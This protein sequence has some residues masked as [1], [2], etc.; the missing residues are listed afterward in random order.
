M[1]TFRVLACLGA[2]GLIL[3]TPAGQ[4]QSFLGSGPTERFSVPPVGDAMRRPDAPPPA[5]RPAA[6]P[7]EAQRE[8]VGRIAPARRLAATTDGF[9]MEGEEATLRFPV[10][11]TEAQTRGRPRLRISYLSAISVAPEASELTVSVNGA[12]VGRTNI[13]AP[14]AVKVVEFEIPEGSLKLGYNAVSL[15]ASQRHRVDCSLNATYELWTQIDPSRSGLVVAPVAAASLELK[16]LPALEPDHSGALPVR[17]V[18]NDKP[19]LPRLERM[20]HAVEA[21]GLIGRIAR[22]VVEFGPPM[23]GRSGL[24]LIVGTAA[25]LREMP[26][27]ES[28]G[29][30]GGPRLVVLPPRP[31]R[32]PTL[33]VTGTSYAEIE[34]A[35]AA[36]A[37]GGE[38]YG[39]PAGLKA[40]SLARGTI[41]DGDETVSLQSLGVSTREFS[42]RLLR[43]AFDVYLPA[44]FLPADYGKVMLN[45]AGAYASGLTSDARILVDLNGSNAASV[46]LAQTR[47]EVF[48]NNTIP[49]PLAKWRPGLNRVAIMAQVPAPADETCGLN[50]TDSKRERFL[51]L[52]RAS[53]SIPTLAHAARI[54]DLAATTSGALAFVKSERRPRLVLPTLDKDT[55]AAAATLAARLAGAA[56]RMIDF[57]LAGDMQSGS[58]G[59]TLVVAP[60]RSL[61]PST[62]SGL[63]LDPDQIRTI[64]QA[65]AETAR[66]PGQSGSVPAPTLDRLRR[67]L[68]PRCSLPELTLRAPA[69]SPTIASAAPAEARRSPQARLSDG[70]L[71]TKWDETLRARHPVLEAADGVVERGRALLNSVVGD[72]RAL[73]SAAPSTPATVTVPPGASLIMAQGFPTTAAAQNGFDGSVT[74]ITAPNALLLKASAACLIDPEV[75]SRIDGRFAFLDASDG[76]LETVAPRNVELVETKT[77]SLS[78]IRLVTA[79]WLSMNPAIYVALTLGLALL[80]GLTT[81]SLV[82]NIGRKN[83]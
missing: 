60:V 59:P 40:A 26:D 9:R 66:A 1:S 65:R 11:L 64:W 10:Y 45:L 28:I 43:T 38:V 44:D 24:N 41:L 23:S 82:R 34:E 32:V 52:D 4:A 75:W 5:T 21:V 36:L 50:A 57:E 30:T 31:D 27:L 68:P 39:T 3:Q 72:P 16:D 17:V 42:G 63:G 62:L 14:G 74:V 80:L 78:N 58:P 18:A 2:L 79:G 22:P 33:V 76:S 15:Q 19:N 13:Q 77:R 48:E 67:N 71:V 7:E 54:P 35:I 37:R 12:V 51:I 61:S 8:P 6:P 70:D 20:I 47:G 29:A 49:L 46:P 55:V 73:F 53:L 25:E 56:G 69:P 83:G 81:T